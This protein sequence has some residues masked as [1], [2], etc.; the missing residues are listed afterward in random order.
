MWL[1][2]WYNKP[3]I[4]FSLIKRVL[5]DISPKTLHACP[6]HGVEGVRSLDMN[7]V[8]SFMPQ[9]IPTGDYRVFIRFHT[10]TNKTFLMVTIGGH[11]DA[12][13]PL[14]ALQMGKK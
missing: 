13:K 4:F 5:D 8:F 6:F 9:V 2:R 11:I 3:G 14:D 10:K 12:I 1:L 7:S